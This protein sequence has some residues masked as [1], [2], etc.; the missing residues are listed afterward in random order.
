[1]YIGPSCGCALGMG[2]N[3]YFSSGALL[4][5]VMTGVTTQT[6]LHHEE[7]YTGHVYDPGKATVTVL[8]IVNQACVLHACLGFKFVSDRL[9]TTAVVSP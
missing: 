7:T 8:A 2:L 4:K 3:C 9:F 1:M 5:S 6:I